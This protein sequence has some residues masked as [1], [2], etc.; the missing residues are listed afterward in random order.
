MYEDNFFA[1]LARLRSCPKR[2]VPLWIWYCQKRQRQVRSWRSAEWCKVWEGPAAES[3]RGRSRCLVQRRGA[4]GDSVTAKRCSRRSVTGW[5]LCTVGGKTQQHYLGFC[6]PVAVLWSEWLKL[7]PF[8]GKLLRKPH[9]E[10]Y[11]KC[12]F[13][14]RQQWGGVGMLVLALAKVPA[15]GCE[16][17]PAVRDVS[18]Q[19]PKSAGKGQSRSYPGLF[20]QEKKRGLWKEVHASCQ[21]PFSGC[22]ASVFFIWGIFVIPV[23]F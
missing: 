14:G 6:R 17:P 10:V 15:K 13:P 11:H 16:V 21:S 22:R 20:L 4:G 23:Y 1:S 2:C 18:P 19:L 8:S 9:Y 7:F 3:S 5:C 12:R